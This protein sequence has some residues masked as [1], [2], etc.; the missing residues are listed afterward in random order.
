MPDSPSFPTLFSVARNEVMLRPGRLKRQIVER[1]GTDANILVA[2]GVAV[3]DAVAAQ[4]AASIANLYLDSATGD[5]LH[6]LGY[7]RYGVVFKGAC[8]A[9]GDETFTSVLASPAAW[10]IPSGTTLSTAD[11]TQYLTSAAV[12]WPLGSFGPITV[13]IRS[14]L[15]GVDQMVDALTLTN[16]VGSIAGAPAGFVFTQTNLL[17]TSGGADDEK[18]DSYRNRCRKARAPKGLLSAIEQGGLSVSGVDTATAFESVNGLGKPAGRVD[19]VVADAFTEALANL[20]QSSP[21][22]A[23]KSQALANLVDAALVE[24]RG[25]GCE[26]T[27]TVAAVVLQ[28]VKISLTYLAGADT[29]AANLE[30]RSRIVSYTNG[31]AP[32]ETWQYGDAVNSLK[33]MSGIFWTGN[34]VHDPAGDVVCGELQVIRTSMELVVVLNA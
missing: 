27:V 17:A 31:L 22:Y 15:A 28:P 7:D 26:V 25:A 1:E 33:G 20:A 10:T 18:D 21:T 2:A 8:P 5:D 11:G 4:Q 23:A 29:T 12:V 14:V 6:K 9:V 34:E 3:G 13:P 32:G 16:L 19:L 24:W 30:A